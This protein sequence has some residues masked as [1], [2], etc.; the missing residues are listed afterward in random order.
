MCLVG[1]VHFEVLVQGV[2]HAEEE[3]VLDYYEDDGDG[4][5]NGAG[6]LFGGLDVGCGELPGVGEDREGV[7]CWWGVGKE[8]LELAGAIGGGVGDAGGGG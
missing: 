6:A 8:G 5:V 1:G 3:E 4:V 2:E 7:G